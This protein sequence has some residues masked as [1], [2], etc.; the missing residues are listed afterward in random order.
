MYVKI[1]PACRSHACTMRAAGFFVLENTMNKQ[2]TK[3]GLIKNI[4]DFHV[5]KSR[6]DG[7]YPSCKACVKV[8]HDEH[9]KELTKKAAEWNA[10]HPAE[11]KRNKRNYVVNNPHKAQSRVAIHQAV[12]AGKLP[13]VTTLIC[14][15]CNRK[16]AEHYHHHRGYE[17]KHWLD[18]IPVCAVCHIDIEGK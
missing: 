18:V 8:Y 13:K 7:R 2:C 14:S 12:A 9:S 11:I 6:S 3:C 15:V 17:R 1:Y 10:S 16:Q 5:E 4:D